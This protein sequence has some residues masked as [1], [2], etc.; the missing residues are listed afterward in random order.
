MTCVLN[1]HARTHILNPHIMYMYVH[2]IVE[3][4]LVVVIMDHQKK[5]VWMNLHCIRYME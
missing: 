3:C 4:V 2:R 1:A 5:T